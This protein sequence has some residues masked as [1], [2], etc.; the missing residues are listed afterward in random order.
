MR[1]LLLCIVLACSAVSA[2]QWVAKDTFLGKL[3]PVGSADY[4]VHTKEGILTLRVTRFTYEARFEDE[5]KRMLSEYARRRGWTRTESARLFSC[6]QLRPNEGTKSV[7][8]MLAPGKWEAV[9]EGK[10]RATNA[11]GWVRCSVSE[12]SVPLPP[13]QPGRG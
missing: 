1:S 6:T 8:V 11:E 2:P 12:F 9:T 3:T 10:I 7:T 4:T 13:D 5:Q